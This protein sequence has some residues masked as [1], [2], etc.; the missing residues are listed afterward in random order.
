MTKYKQQVHFGMT[1]IEVLIFSVLFSMLVISSIAYLYDI[2]ICNAKLMDEVREVES[3]FIATTTIIVLAVGSLFF[4]TVTMSAVTLYADGV[5]H[6]EIR[7]QQRLNDN[8]CVETRALIVAKDYFFKG[9]IVLKDL[10][11]SVSR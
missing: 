7:T 2:H 3:G 8:A 11:C 10:G 9:S 1:L 6:R 4:L 5:D